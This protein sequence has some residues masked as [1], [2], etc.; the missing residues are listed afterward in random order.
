LLCDSGE[1]DL[2]RQYF[3]VSNDDPSR[4]AI[5]IKTNCLADA[6]ISCVEH[7]DLWATQMAVSAEKL[8]Q[9]ADSSAAG[10][11]S[12]PESFLTMA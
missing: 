2:A 1:Q 11:K 3:A 5:G 8:E 10:L 4:Q 12:I 7:M 6:Y 9:V